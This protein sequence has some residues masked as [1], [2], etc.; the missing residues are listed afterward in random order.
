MD[1]ILPSDGHLT[2][3][4]ATDGVVVCYYPNHAAS[5]MSQLIMS[6]LVVSMIM[7][8]MTK[9]FH[10]FMWFCLSIW[11]HVMGAIILAMQRSLA[12][13]AAEPYCPAYRVYV[14]PSSIIFSVWSAASLYF[15]YT[16]VARRGKFHMVYAIILIGLMSGI[17]LGAWGAGLAGAWWQGGLTGLLAMGQI[18]V[19]VWLMVSQD[20]GWLLYDVFAYHTTWT[21]MF[22]PSNHWLPPR[23][24]HTTGSG[25]GG[26][27]MPLTW[28][29]YW[30]TARARYPRALGVSAGAKEDDAADEDDPMHLNL[31]TSCL[32]ASASV[33]CG[34]A[35]LCDGG[36]TLFPSAS[37]SM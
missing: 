21:H 11:G 22:V 18:W 26:T 27:P 12:Q 7:L 20:G 3:T 17:W 29:S 1:E 24:D 31:G 15:A 36:D 16:A 23:K 8:V 2:D 10:D 14:F 37:D 5:V 13:T 19:F 4:T 6:P 30:A 33:L 9:V 34:A 32:Q 28:V 25:G 35:C